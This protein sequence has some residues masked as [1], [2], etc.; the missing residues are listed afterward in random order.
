VEPGSFQ[1][2]PGVVEGLTSLSRQSLS[3]LREQS[4]DVVHPEA[5]A[6]H[7][8]CLD[9]ARERLALV[10]DRLKIPWAL[11]RQK[12]DEVAETS[13]G[14]GAMVCCGHGNDTAGLGPASVERT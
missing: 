10:H 5:D 7:V 12:R 4:I 3:S 2:V 14:C 9:C 13:L 1:L 6:F 11:G 8:K